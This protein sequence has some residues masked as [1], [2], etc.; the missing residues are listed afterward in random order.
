MFIFLAGAAAGAMAVICY[1]LCVAGKKE[2]KQEKKE[3]KSDVCNSCFG[4]AEGSCTTCK[5]YG[6]GG[7]TR[8]ICQ[9]CTDGELWEGERNGI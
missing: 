1:A 2:E 6:I 4:A 9:I 3:T 8:M 7:T 5:W